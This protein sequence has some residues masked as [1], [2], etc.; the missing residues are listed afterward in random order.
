M[1]ENITRV[2]DCRAEYERLLYTVAELEVL[3]Q[4]VTTSLTGMPKGGS[5]LTDDTW[6]KLIDYKKK[7]EDRLNQ[8]YQMKMELEQELDGVRNADIRTALK[9]KYVD[10]LT[11]EAI[12]L[13]MHYSTRTIDRYLRTGRR[14]Y[15][16]L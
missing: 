3:C 2:L 14:I 5:S 6:A 1:A 15:A 4:R 10:G 11:I 13:R 9:Y 8:Y 16:K 12:A 7:C